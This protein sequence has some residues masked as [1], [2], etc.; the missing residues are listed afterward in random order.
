M[1]GGLIVPNIK[2]FPAN[3]SLNIKE[4]GTLELTFLNDPKIDG[5]LYNYFLSMSYGEEGETVVYKDNLPN[6]ETIGN[7]LKISRRTV[8]NH[9]KYLKDRGYVIDKGKKYVLPKV[10]NMYFKV[11]QDTT[12]FLRDTVRE[13]VIKTYVYLG[14][15]NSYKPGQYI[16]T[17]KEICDHLGLSYKHQYSSISNY[18]IALSKFG[19]IEYVE[20]FDGQ[21]PRM[22]LLKVNTEC[23]KIKGN[24]TV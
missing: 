20:F 23:P 3:T 19:L 13:P 10:E 6:Q 11:P 7:I 12:K 22:R 9:L 4:D 16:F 5:E 24:K 17:I 8:I 2:H 14:Q 21:S 1:K 15:R 18:L